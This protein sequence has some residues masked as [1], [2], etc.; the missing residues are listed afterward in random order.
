MNHEGLGFYLRGDNVAAILRD[1]K[2]AEVEVH[3]TSS[4]KGKIMFA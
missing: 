3:A 4:I 2:G 1:L